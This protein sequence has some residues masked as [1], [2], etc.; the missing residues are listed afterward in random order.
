MASRVCP[1][2]MPFVYG[3]QDTA[4]SLKPHPSLSIHPFD[5]FQRNV[6]DLSLQW[7]FASVPNNAKLE[8]VTSTRKQTGTD[9]PVGETSV[10]V[11]CSMTSPCPGNSIHSTT[12]ASLWS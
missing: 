6:L 2:S 3:A 5:R 12:S 1:L 8:V 9:S 4:L 10:C 11:A 7:R